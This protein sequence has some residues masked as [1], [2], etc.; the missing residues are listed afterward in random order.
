MRD[1]D[2]E[3]SVDTLRNTAA[4]RAYYQ[5]NKD[6]VIFR[7]TMKR[8]RDHAIVPT[9]NSVIKY[10]I[11]LQALLVAFADFAG[12]NG[13]TLYILQQKAK[14]DRLRWRVWKEGN[15]PLL[16]GKKLL[17]VQESS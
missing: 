1:P 12:N 5:R 6:I 10:Q 15:A 9:Y 7:K 2:P 3:C 17:Y 4:V 11:P 16:D 8:M 13:C 14:L